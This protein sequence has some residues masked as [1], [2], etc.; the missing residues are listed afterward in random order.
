MRPRGAIG[1]IPGGVGKAGFKG[2]SAAIYPVAYLTAVS[3]TFRFA[4]AMVGDVGSESNG[5]PP[6]PLLL[7]LPR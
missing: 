7:P 6:L 3:T 1:S 2:L 4:V 5:H